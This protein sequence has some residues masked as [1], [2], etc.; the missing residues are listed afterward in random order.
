MITIQIGS[1]T[2]STDSDMTTVLLYQKRRTQDWTN[3]CVQW[4]LW[5]QLG[6][7]RL[8]GWGERDNPAWNP[9]TFSWMKQLTW[10]RIVHSGDWCLRLAPCTPGG[11]CQKRRRMNV[12]T[13]KL[14]HNHQTRPRFL[15]LVYVAIICAIWV[16]RPVVR[17][18]S[19]PTNTN[20]CYCPEVLQIGGA[21]HTVSSTWKPAFFIRQTDRQTSMW[22]ARSLCSR[23]TADRDSTHVLSDVSTWFV[24]FCCGA[25]EASC[26][27]TA[28][29]WLV[30]VLL[31][32]RRLHAITN[33]TLHIWCSLWIK[34]IWTFQT[35][36]M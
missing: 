1:I 31:A 6:I 12:I 24:E 17:W 26:G 7:K 23:R 32:A 14:N 10:L 11:A 21:L 29:C 16:M 35:E 9:I 34:S 18:L 27:P 13:S 4:C 20:L 8:P 15:D 28:L 3:A 33:I 30:T 25:D 19:N 22:L 36:T 2:P 5:K